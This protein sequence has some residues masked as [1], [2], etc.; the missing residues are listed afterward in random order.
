MKGSSPYPPVL[1]VKFRALCGAI[2]LLFREAEPFEDAITIAKEYASLYPDSFYLEVQ[3]KH[4]AGAK[5]GQ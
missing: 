3:S 4:L 1:R 2:T 5:F